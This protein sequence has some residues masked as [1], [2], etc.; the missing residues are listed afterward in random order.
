M[1]AQVV[2]QVDP[3]SSRA[4][5]AVG[6]ARHRHPRFSR[7]LPQH[8][9]R[10]PG[11]L[12]RV[13]QAG[14]PL[15]AGARAPGAP[16]HRARDPRR[17]LRGRSLPARVHRRRRSRGVSAAGPRSQDVRQL[18]FP[19]D[20]GR[21]GAQHPGERLCTLGVRAAPGDR[22]G[23]D[24]PPVLAHQGRARRAPGVC[25]RRSG[26]RRGNVGAGYGRCALYGRRCRGDRAKRHPPQ[27]R[28]LCGVRGLLP[29]KQPVPERT[30]FRCEKGA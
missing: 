2:V 7:A 14:D 1:P 29:A 4:G 6:A 3:E 26:A 8:R 27:R 5:E 22:P 13:R 15:F 23:E 24:D 25:C 9:Q 18:Q 28:R 12:R 10:A 17:H 19:E 20:P 11:L 16:A 21:A 30:H